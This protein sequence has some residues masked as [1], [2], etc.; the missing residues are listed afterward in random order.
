M[1]LALAA[2]LTLVAAP[3]WPMPST[4]STLMAVHLYFGGRLLLS[5]RYALHLPDKN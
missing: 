4:P 2:G 5:W 1:K 3:A